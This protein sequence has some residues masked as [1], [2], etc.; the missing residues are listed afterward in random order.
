[1]HFIQIRNSEMKFV[2]IILFST[3]ACCMQA[4]VNLIRNG[5]MEEK[6]G[7]TCGIAYLLP[8][9]SPIKYWYQH[10]G[11]TPD[12]FQGCSHEPSVSVPYNAGGY[13]PDASTGSSYV[14]IGMDTRYADDE[15]IM[16][17]LI[18]P[19][20]MG[21]KYLFTM[22]LTRSESWIVAANIG[23]CLEHDSI[24]RKDSIYAFYTPTSTAFVFQT[25]TVIKDCENWVKF[26]YIFSPNSTGLQH[27]V[28]GNFRTAG[29]IFELLPTS[30]R[31]GS[32]FPPND[33]Q[34]YYLIDDVSLYCLDCDTSSP[35]PI[36]TPDA[37]TPNADGMNDAWQPL[38]SNDC[39]L[40]STSYLLHIFDR[41][42]NLVFSS[43]SFNEPWK[44]N[45]APLG[46][47][48]FYLQ[49]DEKG[50]TRKKQGNIELIR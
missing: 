26:Q 43:N 40:D 32:T 13:Q 24:P 20:E 9:Y 14:G 8:S 36:A 46:T 4:Q 39:S 12:Y 1:M 5:G 27:L 30:Y 3:C 18:D 11:E 21:K 29:T 6:T 44:G 47:Y 15:Y 28:I 45:N 31:C 33:F 19:L 7:D 50:I 25:D 48:V 17:E 22:Y 23:F 42:G 35:C 38:F 49:Y 2:L 37:F 10:Q 34:S 41:W 16:T